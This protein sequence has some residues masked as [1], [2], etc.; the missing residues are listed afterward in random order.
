MDWFGVTLW[1]IAVVIVL[2]PCKYDPAIRMKEWLDG[3]RET[4][5]KHSGSNQARH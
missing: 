3:D 2:L 5:D 4:K 1:V